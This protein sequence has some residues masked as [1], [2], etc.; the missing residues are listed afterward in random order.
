MLEYHLERKSDITL[1]TRNRETSRYL[2]FDKNNTMSGWKNIKTGEK[3]SC[4]EEE[5]KSLAYSG[6][7]ILNTKMIDRIGKVEKKKN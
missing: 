3:I 5:N 7:T 4:K 1:A 2:L 6:I